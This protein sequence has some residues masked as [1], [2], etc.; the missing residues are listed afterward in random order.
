[1]CGTGCS[2]GWRRGESKRIPRGGDV[3]RARL[4]GRKWGMRLAERLGVAAGPGM[5]GI[6]FME[7]SAVEEWELRS[8]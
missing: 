5:M 7:S 2:V 6:Q 1:M 8:A 4:G 3:S